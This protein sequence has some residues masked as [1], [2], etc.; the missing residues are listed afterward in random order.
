MTDPLDEYRAATAE[1]ARVC[2]AALAD[3]DAAK[4]SM[5]ADP[6]RRAE[7][8][9]AYKTACKAANAEWWAKLC[10]A[11]RVHEARTGDAR[12]AEWLRANPPKKKR[13]RPGN[14]YVTSEVDNFGFDV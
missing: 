12:R 1:A 4:K 6:E 9:D 5:S 13:A 7:V 3:A 8:D 10:A 14:D 2:E 11:G